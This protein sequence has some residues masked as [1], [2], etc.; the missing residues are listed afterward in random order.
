MILRAIALLLLTATTYQSNAQTSYQYSV[1]LNSVQNDKLN[2]ELITPKISKPTVV[3]SF[4]KI[5]PGTYAISDYGK[6]IS[7]VKAFD[8]Q[9]KTLP[10]S[11]QGENQFKISNSTALH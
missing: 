7:G 10:V 1:N 5:I 11:R 8:K 6:F 4:P 9:G 2:I 3:F